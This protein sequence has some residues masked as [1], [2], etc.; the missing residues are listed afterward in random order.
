MEDN[1]SNE[2][3]NNPK[4]A[5]AFAYEDDGEQKKSKREKNLEKVEERQDESP[6][7][8][9]Q[10]RRRKTAFLVMAR[11]AL[12]II[13]VG[14]VGYMTQS[15][16]ISASNLRGVSASYVWNDTSTQTQPGADDDYSVL[17][18]EYKYIDTTK[19]DSMSPAEVAEW[20]KKH[21]PEN[22]E[23]NKTALEEYNRWL[24]GKTKNVDYKKAYYDALEST[25]TLSLTM[26][27]E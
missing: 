19:L 11:V 24:T 14:V 13:A 10:R 22:E 7:A 4:E 23:I 21:F 16:I 1:N 12:C 15:R 9:E 8:Q 25:V 27:A 17:D 2:F 20:Y 18:Q 5:S 26:N 3:W 6:L